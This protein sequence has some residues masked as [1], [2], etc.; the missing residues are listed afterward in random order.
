M[1]EEHPLSILNGLQG[2]SDSG[3]AVGSHIGYGQ[4]GCVQLGSCQHAVERVGTASVAASAGP[5]DAADSMCSGHFGWANSRRHWIS[6]CGSGHLR[7]LRK[8]VLG[9][10]LVSRIRLRWWLKV[11]VHQSVC[12]RDPLR[13]IKLQHSFQ[14][15]NRCVNS[16]Q[17]INRCVN[18]KQGSL[19]PGCNYPGVLPWGARR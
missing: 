16:F 1:R 9:G 2:Q 3:R 12:P 14:E 17:E 4:L 13:R 6:K 5:V 18:C 19:S 10:Q 8:M 7:A 15:I 11:R